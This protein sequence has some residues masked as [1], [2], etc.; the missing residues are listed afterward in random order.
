M[1]YFKN[2]NNLDEA[3]QQYR[4]LAKKL[5]PDNSGSAL[6]F[7]QMEAEYRMFLIEFQNKQPSND[8]HYQTEI[9]EELGNLA[10]T[11]IK[12]QIPQ[13]YLERRIK[14]SSSPIQKVILT[15]F[16]KILDEFNH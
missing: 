9:V 6:Y 16:V 2:I 15:G 8:K 12:K 13:K 1:I 5:H 11:L 3:K 4:K 7:Q 10:M 14:R